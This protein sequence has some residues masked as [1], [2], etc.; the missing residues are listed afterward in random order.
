MWPSP[1]SSLNKLGQLSYLLPHLPLGSCGG[2][3]GSGEGELWANH[4]QEG[5]RQGPH[6]ETK[7]SSASLAWRESC[8]Y[9]LYLT[10]SPCLAFSLGLCL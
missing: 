7:P 6:S 10:A 8:L 9:P 5:L 3:G 2:A 4:R 1:V